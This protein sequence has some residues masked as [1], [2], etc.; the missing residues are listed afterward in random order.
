MINIYIYCKLMGSLALFMTR[1]TK[2][3][4]PTN[5]FSNFS[6]TANNDNLFVYL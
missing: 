6:V 2:M 4:T 1:Y 5:R 3:N